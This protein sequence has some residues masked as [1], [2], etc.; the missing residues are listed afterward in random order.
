MTTFLEMALS[1]V[2]DVIQRILR[3]T[4]P[5]G[6]HP[7]LSLAKTDQEKQKQSKRD[8]DSDD[9]GKT[10]WSKTERTAWLRQVCGKN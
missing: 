7:I 3:E 6:I 10:S 2:I 9:E 5:E 4:V 1:A 8:A